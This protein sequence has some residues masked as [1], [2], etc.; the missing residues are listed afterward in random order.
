M[1]SRTVNHRTCGARQL[2]SALPLHGRHQQLFLST[3]TSTRNSH[4][5]YSSTTN[6]RHDVLIRRAPSRLMSQVHYSNG[7]PL[8]VNRSE[9]GTSRGFREIAN[10]PGISMDSSIG[11][12]HRPHT[13]RFK[14][15]S[16]RSPFFPAKTQPKIY[17]A[18]NRPGLNG[19]TTIVLIQAP[20]CR[21]RI[22]RLLE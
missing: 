6:L 18:T 1:Q 15:R 3:S 21:C 5:D 2:A 9:G 12:H 4:N 22:P 7:A 13:I 19:R 16:L 10:L 20:E 17:I 8:R 14:T 11:S